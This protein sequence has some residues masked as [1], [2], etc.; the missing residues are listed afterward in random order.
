MPCGHM[1]A[2]VVNGLSFKKQ[3]FEIC[4]KKVGFP[5]SGHILA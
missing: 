3:K 1:A 2:V 5:R 4:A